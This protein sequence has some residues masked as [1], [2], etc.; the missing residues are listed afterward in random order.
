MANVMFK[1]GASAN[2]GALAVK[3]GQFIITTDTHELFTDVGSSR[4]SDA[5]T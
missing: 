3:D 1:R 4:D 2:L 5:R